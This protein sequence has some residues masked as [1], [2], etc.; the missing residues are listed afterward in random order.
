[1]KPIFKNLITIA[2]VLALMS[3]QLIKTQ[4]TVTIRNELGNIEEGAKVQLFETE[5]DYKAEQNVA[6]EG[7]TDKKGIIK[8][9]ELKATSYYVIARK[10][11]KDNSGGGEQT[12]K[13]EANKINKVTIIIQ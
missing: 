1:M 12:G 8:F 9:K 10:D 6:A 11:D 5:E 2:F 4:L 13:L 3:F 7:T